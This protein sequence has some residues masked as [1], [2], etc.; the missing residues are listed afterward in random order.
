MSKIFSVLVLI[1]LL[2][3]K[4]YSKDPFISFR[5][6]ETRLNRGLWILTSYKI[7]QV[8]NIEMFKP[9]ASYTNIK[10]PPTVDFYTEAGRTEYNAGSYGI[11]SYYFNKSEDKS[12][13]H[14]HLIGG[15]VGVVQLQSW[16]FLFFHDNSSSNYNERT[17]WLVKRIYG[18]KISLVQ[19]SNNITYELEFEKDK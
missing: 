5:E 2:G 3:C 9:P 4:K 8:E 1:I 6:P 10:Y 15:G 11:G 16:P 17:T 13:L 12:I 7:N 19:Y 14:I 18:K